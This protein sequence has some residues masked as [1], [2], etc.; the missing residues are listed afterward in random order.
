MDNSAI[1]AI[2]AL[3][4]AQLAQRGIDG[5]PEI[6][7]IIVPEDYKIQNL[8]SMKANPNHFRGTFSTRVLS[9]FIYYIGKNGSANTGVFI[10]QDIMSATAI[11]DMG[12]PDLPEWGKHRADAALKLTPAYS[13]LIGFHD[14]R[15]D[16]QNF[17]DFAEDW[18]DNILFYYDEPEKA[19]ALAFKSIIKTLR[20]IKT[21]TTA[22]A[23]NAVENFSRS[24]SAMESIEITAGNEKP[25]T[26]FLFKVIP[27][28]GFDEVTFDCPLRAITDDKAVKLKYRIV[29]LAQHQLNIA[30]QFKEKI[31]SGIKINELA[32]FIGDMAYQQ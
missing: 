7:A 27:Y 12:N 6:S 16:Q 11:L 31:V 22:V 3:S 23:E 13:A 15:L 30:N 28:D 19:D 9:Q 24:R 25:P 18:Q 20:K 8:E 21:S 5:Y 29:Q 10:N 1:Q 2:A 14:A 32:I 17:I 26:G 4:A